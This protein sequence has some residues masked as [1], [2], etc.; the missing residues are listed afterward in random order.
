[1]SCCYQ[2]KILSRRILS[3]FVVLI[4]SLTNILSTYA[5]NINVLN[6][7]P[8]GSM[9][10]ASPVFIPPFIKG[11]TIHP[12][13]PFQFDFIVDAGHSQLKGE[14]LKKESTKLIKYFL[15]T[16][17][18]P[19]E[20]LWVNLSPY[21]SDRI[22]PEDFG[23]TEM[24]RDLLAQDYILKQL[25]A[26]LIY[27][28]EDLG[29]NFW[30]QIY[31][32][33]NTLYGIKEIPVNT[34]NKV[35]IVPEKAVVYTNE[36]TVIVL[37]SHLKVFLEEDY[38]AQRSHFDGKG[39]K[40]GKNSQNKG[41]AFGNTSAA[42]MRKIIIPAIEK[43]INEGKNFATLRQVYQSMILA[44][45]YKKELRHS[46]L[47][48]LYI[49][50]RKIGGVDVQDKEIKQK[51]YDQYLEAYRRGVYDY[52]KEDYDASTKELI[53]RKY[54]SGGILP[55]GEEKLKEQ[56]EKTYVPTNEE[57]Q[58]VADTGFEV[59]STTL[60]IMPNPKNK[61]KAV[62]A[63]LDLL[64]D[65]KIAARD[66]TSQEVERLTRILSLPA[67][68]PFF[69]D[70]LRKMKIDLE[71]DQQKERIAE[72]QKSD[73][74]LK[75][76]VEELENEIHTLKEE[77]GKGEF[78]RA[79]ERMHA[80][81]SYTREV[82]INS[83]L[84]K[85]LFDLIVQ[86]EVGS[87]AER[88]N[89]K[90]KAEVM[91]GL[92]SFSKNKMEIDN[93][94]EYNEVFLDLILD[95]YTKL[96]DD[97]SGDSAK[98]VLDV[99]YG[100][101]FPVDTYGKN[102]IVS[103]TIA[104]RLIATQNPLLVFM[105]YALLGNFVDHSEVLDSLNEMLE[106]KISQQEKFL[107]GEGKAVPYFSATKRILEIS[108]DVEAKTLEADFKAHQDN[109]RPDYFSDRRWKGILE[110][111][112]DNIDLLSEKS[113]E[114]WFKSLARNE[115]PKPGTLKARIADMD[116][117][118]MYEIY[119]SKLT[120]GSLAQK[121]SALE[122]FHSFDTQPL[123]VEELIL[124]F[125]E[126]LDSYPGDINFINRVLGNFDYMYAV[127]ESDT[128]E[129]RRV[130][131]AMEQGAQKYVDH[132]D[133]RLHL[134]ALRLLREEFESHVI[135]KNTVATIKM[136][137]GEVVADE[138]LRIIAKWVEKKI[139][140]FE[141]DRRR[142]L[143]VKF[144]L[145]S[146]LFD[147]HLE[148]L[149]SAPLIANLVQDDLKEYFLRISEGS[150]VKEYDLARQ[151]LGLLKDSSDINP[152]LILRIDRE[153][154][155]AI[156][157]DISSQEIGIELR[158]RFTQ[159][160]FSNNG[161]QNLEEII[162]ASQDIFDE[163]VENTWVLEELTQEWKKNDEQFFLKGL[164]IVLQGIGR[165][166]LKED[167]FLQL[168]LL[169]STEEEMGEKIVLVQSLINYIN[170]D[171]I[172][173]LIH[174]RIIRQEFFNYSSDKSKKYQ[175]VFAS[176]MMLRSHF[177]LDGIKRLSFFDGKVIPDLR[178]ANH[179]AIQRKPFL[180]PA[181]TLKKWISHELIDEDLLVF[182][183]M[184]DISIS[185]LGISLE[186]AL[187]RGI[188]SDVLR[189]VVENMPALTFN[190]IQAISSLKL[191]GDQART[192]ESPDF[193]NALQIKKE[194]MIDYQNLMGKIIVDHLKRSK[195]SRRSGLFFEIDRD[196]LLNEFREKGATPALVR[197]LTYFFV[198]FEEML[199]VSDLNFSD[200]LAD[201]QEMLRI[202]L[203]SAI[204][205]L[206]SPNKGGIDFNKAWL[207]MQSHGQGSQIK[208]NF[209][210]PRIENNEIRGLRPVIFKTT[211][212]PT[213]NP[214]LGLSLTLKKEPRRALL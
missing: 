153:N 30:N 197:R 191:L 167:G 133:I 39:P 7:P 78:Y 20:D 207:E 70:A 198:S 51:I 28:E 172:Y 74:A 83:A 181:E 151:A 131:D 179:S 33:V 137:D 112:K 205:S 40:T 80:I 209:D 161:F 169:S 165:I 128:N 115:P 213:L 152:E 160:F 140:Y 135:I 52:I 106:F 61:D 76:L 100:G 156:R 125:I 212:V 94:K 120:S 81:W 3:S 118:K 95:N 142:A 210:L 171:I 88:L 23:K 136:G 17:T 146:P 64:F 15:A 116:N 104:Q 65:L 71:E 41:D 178:Y 67:K 170:Q 84:S 138:Q 192:G 12:E 35:W 180:I 102:F 147:D 148:A 166:V 36:N 189:E 37:D 2:K 13:N 134:I 196:L 55:L 46:P 186:E 155:K 110:L 53:A 122:A 108:S 121:V 62:L 4:F 45:W 47:N 58:P 149:E 107:Q 126:I 34:F 111:S 16:L 203:D 105:G 50:Q 150:Q 145:E 182:D 214:L 66:G 195:K 141:E 143:R 85:E 175:K 87:I 114:L 57:I 202:E 9:V 43:E 26:S 117:K 127:A 25:T 77:M 49:N 98:V 24:G 54:F 29:K 177:L 90:R 93:P 188:G 201:G 123:L 73:E 176:L 6:L 96:F 68:E 174:L 22:I 164:T 72:A 91:E 193:A 109:V 173:P 139:F 21:E 190:S 42:I 103:E 144:Q 184:K 168:S 113:D 27:P 69:S 208:F 10:Q 183:G 159:A 14:D 97:P 8:P 5:Q 59:N 38:F 157:A 82:T 11:M 194:G 211:P 31:K 132:Q 204:T 162:N 60:V 44:T 56:T 206:P 48:Q 124:A 99:F 101:L 18:T 130:K 63:K 158:D 92:N 79:H 154:P 187:L 89:S 75:Q 129:G 32:K 199:A 86:A 185:V 19:E 1:M 119:R 200:L 163:K